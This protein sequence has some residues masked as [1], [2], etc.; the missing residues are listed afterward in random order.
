VLQ[1]VL[2]R[3]VRRNRERDL[4]AR[5]I[6]DGFGDLVAGLL[7]ARGDHDLRAVLRHP[8]GDRAADA[9]RGACDDGNLS[10]HVEQGH[11][12]LPV[13]RRLLYAGLLVATSGPTGWCMAACLI[14][15]IQGCWLTLG[16][17]QFDVEMLAQWSSRVTEQL[18]ISKASPFSGWPPSAREIA[19]LMV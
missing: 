6:V 16:S 7:L 13:S 5:L 2:G 12:I 4:L 15:A 1:I 17:R 14:S 11:L 9:A 18:S 8:L 10:S 19:A 3:D